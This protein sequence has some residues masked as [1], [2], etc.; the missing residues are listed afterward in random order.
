MFNFDLSPDAVMRLML[1]AQNEIGALTIAGYSREDSIQ[2]LQIHIEE[3][4]RQLVVSREETAFAKED[5]RIVR[6][7][8][9]VVRAANDELMKKIDPARGDRFSRKPKLVKG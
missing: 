8:F 2:Q 3:L 4:N 6:E 1:R 5:S 7:K 9:E